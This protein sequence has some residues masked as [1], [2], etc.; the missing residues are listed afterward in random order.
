MPMHFSLQLTSA[1]NSTR[2][3]H[4]LKHKSFLLQYKEKRE[5]ITADDVAQYKLL[6]NLSEIKRF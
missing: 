6:C 2:A 4:R 3:T 5:T 1:M